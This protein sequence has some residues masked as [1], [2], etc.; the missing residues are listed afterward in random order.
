M[1]IDTGIFIEHL[2]SKD[3]TNT[4]L[5]KVSGNI[6][7][8]VSSVSLYELYMGA[9]NKDKE[10]DVLSLTEDLP[11]LPFN[12]SVAIKAAQIFHQ[13]KADNKLID[14]RD[15]FIAA[16]CLVNNLPILTLNKK[17]FERIEGLVFASV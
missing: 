16:T 4:T 2:R 11:I 8:H 5:Y 6:D 7:L 1:V 13:L 14:F 9:T 15:I 3:K 10:K 12:E 17:H